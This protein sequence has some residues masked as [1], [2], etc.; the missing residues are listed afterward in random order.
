MPPRP[1]KRGAALGR[2]YHA[3][4]ADGY[5]A[6]PIDLIHRACAHLRIRVRGGCEK[7]LRTGPN[8]CRLRVSAPCTEERDPQTTGREARRPTSG[9]RPCVRTARKLAIKLRNYERKP[10]IPAI[11]RPLRG[12]GRCPLRPR[13]CLHLTPRSA[14]PTTSAVLLRKLVLAVTAAVSALAAPGHASA[15]VGD[16]LGRL[17][18]LRVEAS[19]AAGPRAYASLRRIW[20]RQCGFFPGIRFCN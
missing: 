18:E 11:R 15:E 7:S 8:N 20:P 1:S 9:P 5:P 12:G 17:H 16:R 2:D 3:H 4:R 14:G 10:A 19:G 6:T 13:T